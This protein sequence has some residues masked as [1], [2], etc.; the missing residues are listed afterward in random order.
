VGRVVLIARAVA[1]GVMLGAGGA[2]ACVQPTCS[3]YHD[4]SCWSPAPPVTD[5]AI[6]D[7]GDAGD[8]L[9]AEASTEAADDSTLPV[10]AETSTP[11]VSAV[12]T[13]P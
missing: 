4:P 7:S 10:D 5:G 6:S 1:V 12:A 8:A 9:D 11:D 13:D 2:S 3:D